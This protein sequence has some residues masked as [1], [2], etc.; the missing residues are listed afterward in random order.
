MKKRQ[1]AKLGLTVGLVG[2]VGVGGTLAILSQQSNPVTNTFT[3][4]AGLTATDIKLDETDLEGK[5]LDSDMSADERTETGNAYNNIQPGMKLTKDPQVHITAE[6]ADSYVF[7]KLENVDEYLAKV[8]E[9]VAEDKKSELLNGINTNW[10]MYQRDEGATY[11]GVYVYV[12][13]SNEDKGIVA[14]INAGSKVSVGNIA[15]DSEKIFEGIQLSTS[16]ALYDEK[17]EGK[18]LDNI[19]VKALAVQATDT[20]TSWDDAKAVVDAFTWQ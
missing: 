3:V 19:V 9:G 17:G 10:K 16:A 11:D 2:A 1:L 20:A 12:G 8:N 4:G 5:A 7:A 15:F 18:T 6:A 13:T 14:S